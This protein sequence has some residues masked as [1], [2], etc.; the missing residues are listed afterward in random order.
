[1][2]REKDGLDFFFFVKI[3]FRRYVF[4][5]ESIIVSLKKEIFWMRR[6]RDISKEFNVD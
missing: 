3:F 6:I 2:G 5:F 1:M 4:Y